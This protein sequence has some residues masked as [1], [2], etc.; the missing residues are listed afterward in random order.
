MSFIGSL[1]T[2]GLIQN[3]CT[4][5]GN[6]I[7]SKECKRIILSSFMLVLLVLCSIAILKMAETDAAND[8]FEK[9]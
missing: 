4:A 9:Y 8:A 5:N 1:R 2:I 7:G 6:R 3:R